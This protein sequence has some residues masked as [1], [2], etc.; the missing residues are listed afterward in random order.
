VSFLAKLSRF[1]DFADVYNNNKRVSGN[2][3]NI[4]IMILCFR[5]VQGGGG[6]IA[7]SFLANNFS[8]ILAHSEILSTFGDMGRK[9][10]FFV[11]K[12]KNA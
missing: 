6:N 10:K 1:K 8:V 7:E 12:M 3:L 5:K 9:I 2:Y 11:Q 4:L